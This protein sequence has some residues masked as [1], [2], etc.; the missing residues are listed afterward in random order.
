M[1]TGQSK[2]NE[3][4]FYTQ[5]NFDW[6]EEPDDKLWN[7]GDENN[8]VKTDY[9]PCPDGWRVPTYAELS[10]LCQNRSSW[11]SENGQNGSWFSGASSY[12]ETVP[13]V[14]FPVAGYRYGI[15]GNAHFRGYGGLY[16]SSRPYRSYAAYY[17]AF[18]LLNASVPHYD[19]ADGYTIRCVQE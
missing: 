6:L 15:D 14:F 1:T 5:H 9:D 18:G 2:S 8:P 19:R 17:L 12:T 3:K 4:Y 13:Q 7:S 10:E 11:T 16:W